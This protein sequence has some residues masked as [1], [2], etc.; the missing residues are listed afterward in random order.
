VIRTALARLRPDDTF[1]IVRFDDR[2][3]ALGPAPIANKPRNV[4]LTLDWLAKL[5]AGGGTELSTGI[6]AALAVPH[7]PARLRIVAFLTDGYIGNED[8]ILASVAEHLGDSRVFCFGVGSAVNRYLLEEMAALGRGTAQ[9]V[10]PDED[11]SAAVATFE[12]RIDAPVLTDLRVD[13]G[14][15]AVADTVP[16]PMPDLFLGQPLVLTGHYQ[17]GGSG[18]IAV[19]GK[20]GGRYVR[21]DVH[22]DLPDYDAAR[23]A[24][25]TV[26][27]RQRIAELSRRLVRKADSAAEHEIL[28]LAL[29]NRLMTKY[30]AFVAV[31][32]SRVTKPG[33][34]KRVVVPVDV[35][36][37]VRGIPAAQN[38]EGYGTFGYGVSGFGAGGGGVGWGTIGVGHYGTIGHGSG[39]GVGYGAS[40]SY[41]APSPPKVVIGQP[42]VVGDLDKTIIRR[43]VHRSEDKIRY[44]YEKRLVAKPSISGTITAHFT[45]SPAGSVLASKADGFDDE[46]ATCIADVVKEIDFPATKG[47]GAVQINY[48]FTFTS[49]VVHEENAP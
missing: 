14:G 29:A 41:H 7:D 43:Y 31:D 37:A 12:R 15:L 46:V 38:G 21:F 30:T 32:D 25:A 39:I 6:S 4:E 16:N 47:G 11:S 8:Q 13:W 5:D 20:Q 45:V 40:V 1:Q 23:P 17:H 44:C 24:I 26:W 33:D 48:P 35:P 10:R 9:F 18:T 34:G 22:V 42:M 27:A 36:D 49:H 28:A 19:H 3:S 2:A